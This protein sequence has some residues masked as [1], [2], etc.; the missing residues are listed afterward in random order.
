MAFNRDVLSI[1]IVRVL[2]PLSQTLC[3]TAVLFLVSG[4]LKACMCEFPTVQEA[5]RNATSVFRG[6]LSKVDYLEGSYRESNRPFKGTAEWRPRRFLATVEVS[7]FWKG[8]VG[9]RIVL[10]AR[11][12]SADCVGFSTEVGTELLVFANQST[13]TGMPPGTMWVDKV[14]EGQRI[15]T[16]AVCSLTSEIKHA[17]KTLLL[18]GAPKPPRMNE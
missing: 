5:L 8:R 17:T 12:E 11:E 2:E 16:P 4:P 14:A 10:H 13:V 18:L 3:M 7:G 9:R 6:K 1:E 15:T